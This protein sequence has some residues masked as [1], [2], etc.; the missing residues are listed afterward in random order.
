MV[1]VDTA[2]GISPLDP[3]FTDL[4]KPLPSPEE[5]AE[6]ENLNGLSD[7]QLA[8]F[9]ERA[10]P[11]PGGVLRDARRAHERSAPGHP[12]HAH[13][14]GLPRGGL[15]AVRGGAPDPSWLAGIKELRNAT[16]IDLPTSHWPM[17][18]EPAEIARIIGE[19]ARA[20]AAAAVG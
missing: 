20:H 11:V 15:Q 6:E 9:R 3:E 14:H 19:V 5:L 16:W 8:T 4:E 13:L 1:Y 7:E 10:V 17:W 18:S 2:P 12:E